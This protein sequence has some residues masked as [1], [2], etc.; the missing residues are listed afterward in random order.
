MPRG[1]IRTILALGFL[2]G[3]AG[4]LIRAVASLTS[5]KHLSLGRLRL[6]WI[7]LVDGLDKGILRGLAAALVLIAAGAVVRFVWKKA[8][9]PYWQLELRTVKSPAAF[10]VFRGPLSRIRHAAASFVRSVT[11]PS[12]GIPRIPLALGWIFLAMTVAVPILER[13]APPRGPNVL[14]VVADALRPDHLGCYG[15]TAGLSPNIDRAAADSLVFNRA[16]SS[17][18][19]TKPSVGSLMTSLYPREHGAYF[20]Y[21]ILPPSVLTLAE[22]F[23]DKGYATIGIQKNGCLSPG[24]GF[25][26]GFEAYV[27]TTRD[28]EADMLRI[29]ER[30]IKRAGRRPF[31]AYI[32]YMNTHV[33][34][35]SGETID[36]KFTPGSDTGIDI[37]ILTRLGLS[38]GD[39]DRIRG[40]YGKAVAAFDGHF[41]AILAMLRE[42]GIEDDTVVVLT[43]DHGEEL[44]DHGDFEHCHTLYNELL[45]VPLLVRAPSKLP[46]RRVSAWVQ[47]LDLYPFLLGLAG[48]DG[49]EGIRGRDFLPDLSAQAFPEN[50]EFFFEGLLY[51]PARTAIL[52]GDWKLIDNQGETSPKALTLLGPMTPYWPAPN[53]PPFELYDLGADPKELRNVAETHPDIVRDLK[54]RLDLF[55]SSGFG[56]PTASSRKLSK[57]EKDKLRSLGY[58][59]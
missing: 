24:Y 15:S 51:G 13:I 34:Y 16:M 52:R 44:W 19:W 46:A 38:D 35:T 37:R 36:S 42:R 41:G 49:S 33:P 39:K 11:G 6:A 21:D 45:H 20:F 40:F 3:L 28:S 25:E 12:S 53:R 9:A 50:R 8:V 7:T 22:A 2:G 17:A 55:K 43:S 29:L 5:Q 47:H 31:F 58:F 10:R 1:T 56:V 30:R 23:R 48:I 32:H 26:Q 14:L 18:P 54:R 27:D 57:E 59:K 4:G